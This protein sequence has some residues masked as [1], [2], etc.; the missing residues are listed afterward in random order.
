MNQLLEFV[1]SFPESFYWANEKMTE[2]DMDP[3]LRLCKGLQLMK[4]C[5]FVCFEDVQVNTVG[6]QG[7]TCTFVGYP[8]ETGVGSM[9]AQ[10]GNALAISSSCVDKEA[11]WQ[12]VRLFFLPDYQEQLKGS[13]FPTNL[14]VFEDMKQEAMSTRYQRNPDGSYAVDEEGKRIEAD[15]G[16]TLLYGNSYPRHTVTE[17]ETEL[18]DEIIASTTSIL[19]IDDSLKEIITSGAAPYFADQKSAE[20]VA[21]LIQSKANLYVN[22]QR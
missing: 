6:L 12:F 4:Q 8:T 22:E 16:V 18:L 14:S 17:E 3:D 13:V 5:N 15:L 2:D 21:K 1:K 9:F 20:E 7:A 10:F 11:A 19:H